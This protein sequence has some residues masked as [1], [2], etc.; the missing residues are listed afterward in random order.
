MSAA[1]T[2]KEKPFISGPAHKPL[3]D[4]LYKQFF[5]Y[6]LATTLLLLLIYYV[7]DWL[8]LD[9]GSFIRANDSAKGCWTEIVV[10]TAEV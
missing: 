5:H 8:F 10:I 9:S 6:I 7:L 3:Q 4:G 2:V 1:K